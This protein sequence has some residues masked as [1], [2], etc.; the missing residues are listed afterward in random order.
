MTSNQKRIAALVLTVAQ[1]F[2]V[3]PAHASG[4]TPL[5]SLQ[6]AL[7]VVKSF[8]PNEMDGPNVIR[9]AKAGDTIVTTYT[10]EGL[11]RLPVAGTVERT[12]IENSVDSEIDRLTAEMTRLDDSRV[13]LGLQARQSSNPL[14]KARA[15]RAQAEITAVETRLAEARLQRTQ[16]K[17]LQTRLTVDQPLAADE[18]KALSSYRFQGMNVVRNAADRDAALFRFDEL[19]KAPNVKFQQLAR[20]APEGWAK[21]ARYAKP[22][23]FG[24]GLIGAVG[25]GAYLSLGDVLTT[26]ATEKFGGAT[27]SPAGSVVIVTPKQ[28][29]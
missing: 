28:L 19:T 24:A 20:I 12:Q 6:D 14:L 8:L 22:A 7:N 27:S 4:L 26:D 18:L 23:A 5:P 15:E 21:L 29:N 25:I 9:T 1:G 11:R 3:L 10:F 13:A 16:M 17:R 2:A